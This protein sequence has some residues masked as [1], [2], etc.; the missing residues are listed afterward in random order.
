MNNALPLGP[1]LLPYAL[2]LVFAAAGIS[3]L[4]GRRV[5]RRTGVDVEST[6]WNAL[7]VGAV[8]ARLAFVFEYKTLYFSSPLSIIDIRDGGWNATAGLAGAWFYA[9]HR[10]Q[11]SPALRQGL[12]RGLLAGTAVFAMGIGW[13]AIQSG[14][15]QQPMPDLE[16]TA[17]DDQAPAVRLADFSGKPVVVN[18][19]ATW[20]PPCVREMPMFLE[21]QRQ[22]TDVHFVF[23]NQGEDRARVARWL[24]GRQLSLA[25]MLIDDKRQ[26][27]AV[28]K[29]QGYPTTLFF[30]ARGEMVAS[31]LGE[32][33]AATLEQN[34]ERARR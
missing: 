11:K 24:H 15:G 16:L 32:L 30:N 25:N 20:C 1:L 14:P 2:L 12:Q 19:W 3:L 34:L 5:G 27:S 23:I 31:R 9:F 7:A 8:V 26:A 10:Y 28:F 4:V 33:S 18:L 29:Q 17:L 21:A 6:L 22:H 13:L